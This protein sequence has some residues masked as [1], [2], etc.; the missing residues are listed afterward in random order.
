M[1]V[2]GDL[3]E[4]MIVVGERGEVV[5]WVTVVGE[6]VLEFRFMFMLIFWFWFWF[7]A[8]VRVEGLVIILGVLTLVTLVAGCFGGGWCWF[9]VCGFWELLF[10]L[11]VGVVWWFM[12]EPTQDCR[13]PGRELH[14]CCCCCC[15]CSML[16]R[17]ELTRG[18]WLCCCSCSCSWMASLYSN[19]QAEEA[20]LGEGEQLFTFGTEQFY[21]KRRSMLFTSKIR[22]VNKNIY[23]YYLYFAG[24]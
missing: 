6:E 3:E 21:I 14:L 2:E 12:K 22:G 8:N 13:D 1:V 10:V 7:E 18:C 24:K 23:R 19:W 15:C 11:L 17:T 5:C 16:L 9:G 4:C 20:E